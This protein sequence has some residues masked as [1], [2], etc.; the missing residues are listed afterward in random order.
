MRALLPTTLRGRLVWLSTGATAVVLALAVAVLAVVASSQLDDGVDRLLRTRADTARDALNA[1]RGASLPESSLLAQ[2]LSPEGDVLRSSGPS[3]LVTLPLLGRDAR[4]VALR[5]G[6]VFTDVE[7][8][9]G[10]GEVRLYGRLVQLRNP[11]EARRAVLVVAE[12]LGALETLRSVLLTSLLVAAPLVLGLLALAVSVVVRSALRPV[13]ALTREAASVSDADLDR[14]LPVGAADDEVARLSQTLN[15]M[16][17]RIA[18]GVRRERAFVD[19]ASHELRTPVAVLQGELELALSALDEP[20]EVETSVR[21]A[22]AEALRL[23]RMSED[24]LVL[25]RER[26]GTLVQSAGPVDLGDVARSTAARLAGTVDAELRVVAP[27]DGPRVRGDAARLEQAVANLVQNAWAAGARR[28]EV[29]AS[30]GP[31]EAVLEVADDG[32][33]FAPGTETSVFERFARGDEARTRTTGAG[34]GLSIVAAVARGHGGRALAGRD[35]ALGGARV[36]LRLPVRE[37]SSAPG[38]GAARPA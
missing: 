9:D 5:E 21:A 33:G 2:V 17:D 26:A 36:T 37:S 35:D 23:R 27:Q 7:A 20:A 30:G 18:V 3:A 28:V 32:P 38:G 19:D 22:H 31:G 34:L 24:L 4:D 16:L 14:R 12:P 6:E 29:R 25:A 13:D 8:F 10:A 1:T 15:A 11:A